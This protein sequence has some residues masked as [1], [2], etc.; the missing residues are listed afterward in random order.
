MTVIHT[1]MLGVEIANAEAT[2]KYGLALGS[3]VQG[4][5]G[6]EYMYVKSAAAITQY[7]AVGIDENCSA[8]SLTKAMADDGYRGGFSQVA[9]AGTNYYGWVATRGANINCYVGASCAADAALYTSATAGVLDDD[10]S[11]QTKIDGVVAVA[12]GA[13]AA[14]AVEIIATFPKSTTF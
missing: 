5:D 8:A 3:L 6:N 14:S 7:H 12:A 13:T 1:G 2:D 4:T 11:S 9:F 10:S